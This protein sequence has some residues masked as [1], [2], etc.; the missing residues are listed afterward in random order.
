[1]ILYFYFYPVSS[2]T[3]TLPQLLIIKLPLRVGEKFEDFGILL[4]NDTDG[5]KLAIIKD[6]C[7]KDPERI[8][9]E[10]LR[11]WLAGRGVDM[12]WESLISVLNIMEVPLMAKQL[13][14]ALE[15]FRQLKSNCKCT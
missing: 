4:L 2:E 8:I 9:M 14:A 11:E 5:N 12:S 6:K 1:M 13:Q 3:P 10:I 7:L 15:K